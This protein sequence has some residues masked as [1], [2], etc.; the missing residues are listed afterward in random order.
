MKRLFLGLL[1]VAG[2]CLPSAATTPEPD[3]RTWSVVPCDDCTTKG[4][5]VESRRSS[6]ENGS[7][8]KYTYTRVSNLNPHPIVFTLDLTPRRA[9][10]G[11]PDVLS[12]QWRVTLPAAEH[13]ES[14]TVLSVDHETYSTARVY[15]VERY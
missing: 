2:A 7:V 8:G 13:A 15:G 1:V 5:R 3:H 11:D 10:S 6:N 12:K 4:V 14:S 9:A